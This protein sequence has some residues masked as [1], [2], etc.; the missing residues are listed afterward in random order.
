MLHT[1]FVARLK[2]L[3]NEYS[4][5]NGSDTPDYVLADYLSFC[6]INFDMAIKKREKWHGRGECRPL[7]EGPESETIV[8]TSSK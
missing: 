7:I 4:A 2:D 5:E 8:E 1:D 3:L 6:L